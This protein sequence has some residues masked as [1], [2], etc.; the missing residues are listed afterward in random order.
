MF[1]AMS[2]WL[3]SFVCCPAP[4]PPWWT[5][6]LPMRPKAGSTAANAAAAP[7]PTIARRDTAA[8]ASPPETP[9]AAADRAPGAGRAQREGAARGR[10]LRDLDGERRLGGRHVDEHAALAQA[11]QRPLR[12][13]HDLPHVARETHHA[14]HD[15]ASLCDLA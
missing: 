4:G 2:V 10:S 8:P 13:E 9:R 11:R 5:I 14:E 7:P 6:V 12:P 1:A 15:V 3:T